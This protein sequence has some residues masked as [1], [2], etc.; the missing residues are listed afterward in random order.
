[1]IGILGLGLILALSAG[2]VRAENVLIH[3]KTSL[4]QDDAQICVVPNVAMAALDAGDD[5]TLLFD[6]SAV[7]SI[8]Q[9]W[10][11]SNWGATTP[12]DNATAPARE[13]KSIADQFDVPLDE[14]PTDYGAYLDFLGE[15][16]VDM[17]VNRTMLTLYKINPEDV[18]PVAQPLDA[19]EMYGLFKGADRTLVY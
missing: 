19:K 14:V 13:R 4:A 12:M 6:A 17:Y 11:W 8:T 3:V 18:D 5:V 1:M 7:T 15:R 10:G 2:P 16:G 9:G